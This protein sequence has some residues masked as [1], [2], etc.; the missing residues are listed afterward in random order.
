MATNIPIG[1]HNKSAM[2]SRGAVA[3]RSMATPS[4]ITPP[5]IIAI[6]IGA[7]GNTYSCRMVQ[8]AANPRTPMTKPTAP[9][10]PITLCLVKRARIPASPSDAIAKPGARRATASRHRGFIGSLMLPTPASQSTTAATTTISPPP[11]AARAAH[12]RICSG[13]R[14]PPILVV[15]PSRRSGSNLLSERVRRIPQMSHL[16]LMHSN[17][18]KGPSPKPVS[19]ILDE[20]R[21]NRPSRSVSSFRGPKAGHK[22]S[23]RRIKTQGNGCPW[24]VD[25]AA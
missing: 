14:E 20:R 1:L 17:A 7:S 4:T 5:K 11:T 2:A 21:P 16:A 25:G 22:M 3:A 12:R 10:A 24:V 13:I 19:T 9:P 23:W 15:A 8:L 18:W 6:E